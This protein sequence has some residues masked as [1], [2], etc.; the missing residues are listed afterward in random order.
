MNEREKKQIREAI[1]ELSRDF[2][3]RQ[4][5]K[6]K[7]K[8]DLGSVLSGLAAE[9]RGTR[10]LRRVPLRSRFHRKTSINRVLFWVS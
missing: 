7:T 8:D 6:T 2:F 4:K 3:F 5:N 9:S 1:S 10:L